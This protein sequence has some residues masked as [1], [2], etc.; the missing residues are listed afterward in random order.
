[1]VLVPFWLANRDRTGGDDAYLRADV[2]P[3][4]SYGRRL[5]VQML[6]SDAQ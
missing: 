4:A 1:M 2:R 6:Q 3:R 5:L